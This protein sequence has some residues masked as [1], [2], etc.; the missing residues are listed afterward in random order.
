MAADISLTTAIRNNLLALQNVTDLLSRTQN[1]LST[2]LRVASPLDD[3]VAFFQARALNDR[4]LDLGEKKDGIDQ[5]ISAIKTALTAIDAIDNTVK[6]IK[7]LLDNSKSANATER[8]TLATQISGLFQQI[9]NFANDASYQGNNIVN[10][11]AASLNIIFS[12]SI[13]NNKLT[14][15]GLD[16]QVS[17]LFT[18]AALASVLLT[19]LLSAAG[20]TVGGFSDATITQLDFLITEVNTAISRLRGHGKGLGSNVA[21][22]QTRLEF[23]RVYVNTLEEGAGKLTLADLNQEG[24]NMV[25]LQTR[26]QLSLQSLS[27][28]GQ[29][30]QAILQ[31]F[32]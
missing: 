11:T 25:A 24:A 20:M 29:S 17:V 2:G 23:S 15:Q 9:N 21:L 28:A 22:L 12:D 8:A 13:A 32:R 3:A 4:A 5:G 31:L 16:I 18:N 7:G 10:S 14:I 30:E 26:Q 1:R 6:Q 27:F 19:T